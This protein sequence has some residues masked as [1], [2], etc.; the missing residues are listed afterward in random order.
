[1]SSEDSK[2]VG[3]MLLSSV[4]IVVC[5]PMALCAAISHM[6]NLLAGLSMAIS[7]NATVIILCHFGY[8]AA[9]A[10]VCVLMSIG[11][12]IFIT[13]FMAFVAI[14]VSTLVFEVRTSFWSLFWYGLLSCALCGFS[15]A[16]MCVES[17]IFHYGVSC[18][19]V[20][21][22]GLLWLKLLVEHRIKLLELEV[23]ERKLTEFRLSKAL[24][25][26]EEALSVRTT[27]FASVSHEIRT[28]MNGILGHAHAHIH[29]HT[30][31]YMHIHTRAYART[32]HTDT[33]TP[34]HTSSHAREII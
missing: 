8:I 29:T 6:W 1:M 15:I 31:M 23:E 10:H 18:M 26:T 19:L 20:S 28:P 17:H 21:W 16:P 30:R 24:L 3:L 5:L 34:T 12:S 9:A 4:G 25:D 14:T 22:A 11:A 2:K 33:H 32:Q 7:T 13:P 27:F